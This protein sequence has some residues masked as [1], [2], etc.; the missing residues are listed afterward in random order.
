MRL[1]LDEHVPRAVVQAL[2]LR[3]VDVLTAREDGLAGFPDPVL[4]DRATTLGYVLC[5]QDDDLRV[6]AERRSEAGIPHAGIVYGHPLAVTVGR[7]VQDLAR[8]A[9]LGEPD[10]FADRVEDLPL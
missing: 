6:E 4:L 1:Y 2:R 8:I 9:S 5:T 10:D 7:L 3:G